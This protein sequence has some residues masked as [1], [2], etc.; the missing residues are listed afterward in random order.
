VDP[1]AEKLEEVSSLSKKDGLFCAHAKDPISSGL[2]LQSF[3]PKGFFREHGGQALLLGAG[4]SALAMSVYLGDGQKADDIPKVVTIANR[5]QPRLESA[6]ATL[7]G[8]DPQITFNYILNPEP[9][10]NDRTLAALPPY[11]LIVNA[12]GLGKDAPGSPITDDA[13]FPEHSLVWEL[14]YRGDL[15]FQDQANAQAAAKDLT[16]EGG[17]TYFIHGWTQVIAEVF[18]IDISGSVLEQLSEIAKG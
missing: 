12:T 3:V 15:V 8:L 13:V 4:G 11:S 2:T 5:S 18:H 7:Q 17:W 6:K 14:N 1:Y 10:G 9:S 16:V